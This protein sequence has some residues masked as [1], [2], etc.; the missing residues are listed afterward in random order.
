MKFIDFSW[1]RVASS[2]VLSGPF[3]G[4][5]TDPEKGKSTNIHSRNS[6]F[7]R[8]VLVNEALSYRPIAWEANM[9]LRKEDR[10]QINTCNSLFR[11]DGLHLF[12]KHGE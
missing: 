4:E 8:D 9:V 1:I 3:Y 10:K 12:G 5:G 7:V 11:C 2:A 6:C